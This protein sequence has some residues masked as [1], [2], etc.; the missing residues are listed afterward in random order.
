M[1]Y[2]LTYVALLV[3]CAI[4]P[5]DCIGGEQPQ[6]LEISC[7]RYAEK[8]FEVVRVD[9]TRAT[10]GLYWKDEHG[11][12]YTTFDRL[13]AGLARRKQKLVFAT[14][15]GI[16]SKQDTPLG[17]HIEQGTELSPL[18]RSSGG[19]NFFLLP[20]GV[21]LVQGGKAQVLSTEA[22]AAGAFQA[23]LA[24]Q[25]GPALVLDNTVN[26][27]FN[28]DS[29]STFIRSGV[30]VFKDAEAILVLSLEPVNFYTFANF[31]RDQLNCPNALYLDGA[32]SRFYLPSEGQTPHLGHFVGLL[33]V[34]ANPAS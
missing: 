23:E 4:V 5:G 19:G 8:S 30:G 24:T 29:E 10:L 18:N 15:A 1:R 33:G 17:L 21:F 16:Y 12:P 3:G 6:G 31:F 32:I 34:T 25:S 11:E 20:N 22:Y 14:N 9:L 7:V 26:A 13:R 27:A 2:L 28:P